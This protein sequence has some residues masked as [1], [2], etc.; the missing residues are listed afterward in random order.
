MQIEVVCAYSY[1]TI[2]GNVERNSRECTNWLETS[3]AH[4]GHAVIIGGGPSLVDKLPL[5]YKRRNA[6]QTFFAL[7]GAGP[8]LNGHGIV[9]DYQIFLDCLPALVDRI[10]QAGNYLIGSQ[11]DPAMFAAVPDPILWHAG[12]ENIEKY[13]PKERFENG[14]WFAAGGAGATVGLSALALIYGMGFRKLHL[15]GYDC[16]CK[17]NRLHAYHVPGE[18]PSKLENVAGHLVGYSGIELNGKK[19]TST[20][21]MTRQAELFPEVCQA[22]HLAGCSV[23]VDVHEDSLMAEVLRMMNATQPA[24]A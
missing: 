19:F 12:V 11:C 3:P 10:G 18:D 7:N 21:A 15:F 16:S 17:D 20:L 23:T 6:G 22:L 9:P 8:W 4:G 14:N 1:E 2:F 24:A 5:L 13:L